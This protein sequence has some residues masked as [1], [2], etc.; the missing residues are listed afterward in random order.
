MN[1]FTQI[2]FYLSVIAM[3]STH[4]FGMKETIT[5]TVLD[6]I[7]HIEKELKDIP[8]IAPLCDTQQELTKKNVKLRD[9]ANLYCELE[10]KGVPVVLLA[11]GPGNTH[12]VF[13][14]YFSKL[15]NVAHVVY[16][17]FRGCGKSDFIKGDGYSIDQAVDD[18][19][20]LRKALKIEKWVVLGHSNG[21]FL[22][23]YYAKKYG[24][25]VL[26]L[27]LVSAD[28]DAKIQEEKLGDGDTNQRMYNT[29]SEI[30]RLKEI[31]QKAFSLLMSEIEYITG[32]E[33][34]QKYIYNMLLNGDWKRQ[35]FYCPTHEEM[36]RKAM[37]EFV[38]DWDYA[39]S[40]CETQR[41]I[42]ITTFDASIPTLIIEGAYDLTWNP[43]KKPAIL[44]S[45]HK[46]AQ[47]IIFDK[48]AHS[49]F[50]DEPEKF[51]LSLKAF[52]ETLKTMSN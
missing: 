48:S 20:D 40:M 38:C 30:Q 3:F 23:Q 28:F 31:R 37:S 12:Q 41:T 29:E 52:M 2:L 27:I 22:A 8:Q 39:N 18:L 13:H 11:G 16:F 35:C 50:V 15:A 19:E 33:K 21:G 17:D 32:K 46:H 43:K 4:L 44:H 47:L 42:D 7:E 49:P 9:G 1:M 25:H 24:P 6:H 34:L 45:I 26:G 36:A 51:F 14:P 5:E 10:G